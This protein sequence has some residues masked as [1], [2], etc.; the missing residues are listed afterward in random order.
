MVK[1]LVVLH[2]DS[3]GRYVSVE[4]DLLLIIEAGELLSKN[5]VKNSLLYAVSPCKSVKFLLKNLR[6]LSK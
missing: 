5:F 1:H 3:I 4:K 6:G 2:L